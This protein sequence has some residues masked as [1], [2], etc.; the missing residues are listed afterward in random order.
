M[1]ET[2]LNQKAFN[3]W[4][5]YIFDHPVTE[6]AWYWE[7]EDDWVWDIPPAATVAYITTAFENAKQVF[8]PFS[9]AQLNQ[10]LWYLISNSCSNQI[11]ALL[12][13]ENGVPWLDRQRCIRSIFTL[14]QQCIAKRCSPH[15]GHLDEPNANPLNSVCYMWW[16][17]FPWYGHPREP[18]YQEIDEEFINVMQMTLQLNSDPCRESALHGLGHWQIY[19]PEKITAIID[20]F[21]ARN[22]RIR[23]EL[24]K[25]A[26][27]ARVGYVQ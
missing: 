7:E 27:N 20:D 26:L 23:P 9:D 17:I 16:D 2:Q 1:A 8:E 24:K 18:M 3:N 5:K 10:G 13:L 21:L 6:P 22:P 15:L 11:F 12:Q 4:I 19:Y 25:Y 14:F